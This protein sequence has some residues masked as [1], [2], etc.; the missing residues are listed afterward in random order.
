VWDR[1]FLASHINLKEL[2]AV[3]LALQAFLPW[4]RSKS[5][6]VVSDNRTVV[7]LIRNQG[8]V[9]S[10]ALHQLSHELLTWAYAHQI[11]LTPMFQ[12]G[13]LNVLADRLSRPN[14]V[15][16]TEWSLHQST[17]DQ[18]FVRL[19]RPTVDLFATRLNYKLPTYVSPEVDPAASAVDALSLDWRD[20]Y[21]YAFPPWTLLLPVLQKFCLAPSRLILIAPYWPRMPWFPL[22]AKCANG[23]PWP[24]PPSRD[25]LHQV[26]G[27][28]RIVRHPNPQVLRLHAWLLSSPP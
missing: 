22:L 27:N 20:M 23:A 13:I 2:R 18:V 3:F 28:G 8:T 7:A 17:V 25:L 4:V 26:L 12:P 24:L 15:I 1:P 10:P 9:R 14:T 21:A 16:A 19:G 6:Q 11:D 5:L